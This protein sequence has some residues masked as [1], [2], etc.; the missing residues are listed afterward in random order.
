MI[1]NMPTIGVRF[2]IDKAGGGYYGFACWKIF[3]QAITPETIGVASL[4]EGDTA[5]TLN[6]R[7]RVFC[8]AVQ[9][10]DGGSIGKTK[11]ALS[12]SAAFKAVCA[13]PMF[14]EG[15][16]CAAE[17]L[18]DA[19][20][21]DAE[22]DLVGEAGASRSALGAV[23]KERTAAAQG[24]EEVEVRERRK[25]ASE[26]TRTLPAISSFEEL[27]KFIGTQF[28]TPE[29]EYGCWI[30]PE[31]L[32]D[33][34]ERYADMILLSVDEYSC[35]ASEDMCLVRLFEKNPPG[36]QPIGFTGLYPFASLSDARSFGQD[37]ESV[38]AYAKALPRHADVRGKYHFNF[39]RGGSAENSLSEPF[40]PKA[41]ISPNS[42][43]GKLYQLKHRFLSDLAREEEVAKKRAEE[44]R[45]RREE[46]EK[47]RAEEQKRR[48]AEEARRKAEDER[49]ASVQATPKSTGHCIMCGQPLN[50]VQKLFGKDRHAGC[51]SFKE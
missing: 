49:R 33:V 4:Y 12:R 43:W 8:I 19:G 47:R 14:V 36:R 48:E 5:A 26:R 7:E 31:E 1:S 6:G 37:Y 38:P 51:A 25:P 16:S 9:S 35:G 23:K 46:E 40:D 17:P 27:G 3:W 13:S 21:I 22:G 45:K 11:A 34:V 41:G 32:C 50:F 18:P 42:L 24:G 10:L 44:D 29:Y 2:D 39:T 28:R 20:R 30:T 15:S